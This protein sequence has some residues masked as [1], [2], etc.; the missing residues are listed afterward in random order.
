MSNNIYENC[1]LTYLKTVQPRHDQ[2]D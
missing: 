1:L 2:N